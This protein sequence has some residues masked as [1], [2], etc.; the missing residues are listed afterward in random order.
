MVGDVRIS[1]C[2]SLGDIYIY[3]L[4]AMRLGHLAKLTPAILKKCEV[5]ATVSIILLH[6][7]CVLFFS[8]TL[9]RVYH[10][11]TYIRA[12]YKYMRSRYRFYVI[13]VFSV[14][15]YIHIYMH[16]LYRL[17]KA[18]GARIKGIHFI[19][20][21]SFIDRIVTLVKSA[22]KPKLAARVIAFTFISV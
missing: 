9:A 5:A 3:D 18:Y 10:V 7:T 22:I 8:P 11:L 4:S 2:R 19:N 21:P 15:W 13:F 20:A 17:Q 6:A 12:F 16:T 1:E 14:S